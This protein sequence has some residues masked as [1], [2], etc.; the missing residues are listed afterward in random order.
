MENTTNSVYI[1][2]FFTWK[3]ALVFYDYSPYGISGWINKW[4]V[5]PKI[6]TNYH[7]DYSKGILINRTS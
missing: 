2:V 5:Y 3:T 1:T 6:Y 4:L 7:L